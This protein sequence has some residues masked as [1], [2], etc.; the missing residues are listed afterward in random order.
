MK[1]YTQDIPKM[2]PPEASPGGGSPL[3]CCRFGRPPSSNGW[4]TMFLTAASEAVSRA[5]LFADPLLL[6]KMELTN[7]AIADS[8]L[9]I[10]AIL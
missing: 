7:F 3:M 5:S 1:K 9:T 10:K 6:L 4:F 8:P 2:K